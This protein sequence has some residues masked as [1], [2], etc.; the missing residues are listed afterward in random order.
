[1][2]LLAIS[3]IVLIML[4]HILARFEFQFIPYLLVDKKITIKIAVCIIHRFH[5]HGFQLI[6][7]L[8][9]ESMVFVNGRPEEKNRCVKKKMVNTGSLKGNTVGFVKRF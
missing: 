7:N 3:M 2:I 9:L 1:M 6:E 8:D 4:Y 5:A